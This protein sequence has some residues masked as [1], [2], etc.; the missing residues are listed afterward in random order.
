MFQ[1]IQWTR[2]HAIMGFRSPPL[3][4]VH[5]ADLVSLVSLVC[6]AATRGTWLP[7]L[8]TRITGLGIYHACDDC[9]FPTPAQLGRRMAPAATLDD[10]LAETA[11]WLRE[12]GRL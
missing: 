11:G 2:L 7:V 9:G 4:L 3:A 5:V 6:E 10:R 1:S 8:T 12:N